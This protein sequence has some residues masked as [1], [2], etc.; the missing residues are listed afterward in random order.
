MDSIVLL[1]LHTLN[2][3]TVVPCNQYEI[4]VITQDDDGRL[5]ASGT[6]HVQY[7]DYV[8]YCNQYV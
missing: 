8:V 7:C 3:G 1:V 6:A 4:A 5:G 2:T